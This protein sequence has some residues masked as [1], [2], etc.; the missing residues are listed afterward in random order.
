MAKS[1]NIRLLPP[2]IDRSVAISARFHP[3][4]E[5]QIVSKLTFLMQSLLKDRA[6]LASWH[7]S[8]LTKDG[9]PL[10]FA[11]TSVN[12]GIRYTTEIEP[13]HSNIEG[14]LTRIRQLLE[15]SAV[16]GFDTDFF[17]RLEQWQKTG[18]LKFGAWL[19]VRQNEAG[20]GYKIYADIPAE[21]RQAAG[22]YLNRYLDAPLFIKDRKTVLQMIGFYP[23]TGELEFYFSVYDIRPW[24]II[25]LMNPVGLEARHREV[26]DHFQWAYGKPIF[27]R[28]PGYIY[29]FSYALR[30]DSAEYSKA[31]TFYTFTDTL[32]GSGANSR[33]KLLRYYSALGIDMSYYAEMSK[34]EKYLPGDKNHHGLFGVSIAQN[35]PAISH[36]GLRPPPCEE[37]SGHRSGEINE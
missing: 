15:A 5:S 34:P 4:F 24:E 32:F 27:Q 13:P 11:F 18:R 30:P 10:E 37:L 1:E 26:L 7:L 23:A 14:R 16:S 29:G 9:Y 22:S 36:V 31:F 33:R 12:D 20:A 8:Q 19:G 28:L 17:A 6:N 2:E 21:A 3:G 25:A 35:R